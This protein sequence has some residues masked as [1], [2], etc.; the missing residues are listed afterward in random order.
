MA[1]EI[2]SVEDTGMSMDS[3]GWTRT[4]QK[5]VSAPTWEELYSGGAFPVIGSRHPNN[6]LFRLESATMTQIGNT[7]GKI[8]VLWTGTYKTPSG[9]STGGGSSS[10]SDVDPWDLDATNVSVGYSTEQVPFLK[11]WNESGAEVDLLN[12][13][14]CRIDAETTAFVTELTFTY[15]VKSSGTGEPPVNNSPSINQSVQKVAGYSIPA[16]CGMLMPMSATFMI[17]YE[18]DNPTK[19]KRTYWEINVSIRINERGWKKEFL[20]VGTM[21][22]FDAGVPEPIYQYT[23]NPNEPKVNFGSIGQ[24]QKAKAEFEKNYPGQKMGWNEVTDPLPL[25]NGKIFTEALQS[26]QNQYNKIVIYDVP[27]DSWASYNL[28]SKR[29]A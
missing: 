8:Q 6:T 24:V 5:I 2:S 12:S 17:E 9:S 27:L 19:I 26:R 21:A 3:S 14:G 18:D 7:D 1:L 11:G 29:E 25:N 22:L 28:P 13:A 4:R 15:C 20:D 16:K 23:P 10:G